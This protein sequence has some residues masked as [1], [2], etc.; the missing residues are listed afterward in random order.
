M[1]IL[2][3]CAWHQMASGAFAAPTNTT[4]FT[5]MLEKGVMTWR[6]GVLFG[7]MWL[8]I[9]AAVALMSQSAGREVRVRKSKY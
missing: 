5:E 2:V 6:G 1:A 7:V 8:S 3:S 4:W 9:A